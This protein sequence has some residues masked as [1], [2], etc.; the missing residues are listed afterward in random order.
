MT[1]QDDKE[2]AVPPTEPPIPYSIFTSRQKSLIVTTVAIAATF[3]GIA[4]NIYFPAIPEIALDLSVT[5]EL[6]MSPLIKPLIQKP[7]GVLTPF[8]PLPTFLSIA[9]S[10]IFALYPENDSDIEIFQ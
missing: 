8:V 7:R 2:Q 10:P 3:S 9:P 1:A 4:S 5:P 6:S